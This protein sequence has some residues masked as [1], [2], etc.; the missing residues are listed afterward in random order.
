[1]AAEG[2]E[3]LQI[4][5]LLNFEQNVLDIDSIM[6][7]KQTSHTMSDKQSG[8]PRNEDKGVI[9]SEPAEDSKNRGDF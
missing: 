6:V 3:P 8:R 9:D 5:N 1:M 4:I 7:P 2:L